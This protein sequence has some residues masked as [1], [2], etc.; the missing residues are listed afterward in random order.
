V[1][2]L[3]PWLRRGLGHGS[4][5]SSRLG[6]CWPRESP[7]VSSRSA[8]GSAEP[9][10]HPA[11]KPAYSDRTWRDAPNRAPDRTSRRA[12]HRRADLGRRHRPGPRERAARGRAPAGPCRILV[13][14]V[15]VV[16][17]TR[18]VQS[19]PELY[20]D[21]AIRARYPLDLQQGRAD[22]D[23]EQVRRRRVGGDRLDPLGGANHARAELALEQ[24]VER[25][26]VGGQPLGRQAAEAG[27][28]QPDLVENRGLALEVEHPA[29]AHD[30]LA[31]A[32]S[33][34]SR[35]LDRRTQPAALDDATAQRLAAFVVGQQAQE[36]ELG[37][38]LVMGGDESAAPL[39]A[40]HEVVG[41]EFVDRLAHRALAHAIA[42]GQFHLARDRFARLPLARLQALR[43][44]PLD[45]NI[46]RH[47]AGNIGHADIPRYLIRRLGPG[48]VHAADSTP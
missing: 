39:S 32:Q 27:A 26:A 5:T 19:A 36:A 48:L 28:G 20:R 40:D 29:D 46:E 47:V 18:V 17:P 31:G 34:D 25:A 24:A 30:R 43:Q 14:F 11:I 23:A 35:D 8:R 12:P 42:A 7:L 22:L 13:E 4:P 21:I 3:W 16:V 44:Q 10:Q 38:C 6:S 9:F 33:E 45:L 15:E 41:R 37:A 1:P 2:E